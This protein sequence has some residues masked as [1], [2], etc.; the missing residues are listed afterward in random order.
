MA[1]AKANTVNNNNM[2]VT[3]KVA[4]SKAATKVSNNKADTMAAINRTTAKVKVKVKHTE[5]QHM[6]ASSMANREDMTNNSKVNTA[7][8][9]K[10][11]ILAQKHTTNFPSKVPMLKTNTLKARLRMVNKDSSSMVPLI[12]THK[13][14]VIED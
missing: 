11:N 4:T 5:H 3:T 9:N 7:N 13:L 6:A 8:S 12:P 2:V 14:R 1:K 10:V